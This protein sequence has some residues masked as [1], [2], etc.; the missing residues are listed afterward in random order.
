MISARRRRLRRLRVPRGPAGVPTPARVQDLARLVH[1]GRAVVAVERP[2]VVGAVGPLPPASAGADPVHVE[3][4]GAD[5]LTSVENS[6]VGRHEV[7]G[8]VGD[9]VIDSPVGPGQLH[10][11]IAFPDLR[12]PHHVPRLVPPGHREHPSIGE[13]RDR[14]IPA[15]VR[16]VGTAREAA[17]VV[18]EVRGGDAPVVL[19]VSP[20]DHQP[21]VRHEGMAG[22]EEHRVH[23]D[24][25]ERFRR[26]RG[27]V[28]QAR[29]AHGVGRV[30]LAPGQDLPIRKQV[31]VERDD[32]PRHDG[33][34]L[35]AAR[36]GRKSRHVDW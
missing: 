5:P 6:S 36:L 15:P 35:A 9:L 16:H 28:P 11:L 10:P 14:G 17:V 24:H 4:A 1:R 23:V 21:T 34:P 27:R 3:P 33:A 13:R 22:A 18:E 32:I 20:R 29:H 8:I 7:P 26:A 19:E 31:H 2:D 25:G 12:D 30:G